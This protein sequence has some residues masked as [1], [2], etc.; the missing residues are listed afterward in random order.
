M[1]DEGGAFLQNASMPSKPEIREEV[2][3][4]EWPNPESR[5]TSHDTNKNTM[6]C[7]DMGI[8][9]GKFGRAS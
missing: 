9:V 6:Q 1:V 5:P 8:L 7:M 3:I 2:G 4:M